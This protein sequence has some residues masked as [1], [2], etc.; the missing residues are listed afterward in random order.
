MRQLIAFVFLSVLSLQ[1]VAQSYHLSCTFTGVR[2]DDGSF[3]EGQT[4]SGSWTAAITQAEIDAGVAA[5][6]GADSV[7]SIPL[8]SFSLEPNPIP[9][10]AIAY[11]V[12][13]ANVEMSIRFCGVTICQIYVG[14]KVSSTDTARSFFGAEDLRVVYT[15]VGSAMPFDQSSWGSSS[16]FP[17]NYKWSGFQWNTVNSVL[18]FQIS[19]PPTSSRLACS[20]FEPP[21]RDTMSI[22]GQRVIPLKAML[23]DSSGNVVGSSGIG[24]APNVAVEF[25]PASSGTSSDLGDSVSG[26]GSARAGRQF[27]YADGKWRFNLSTRNFSNPGTYLVTMTSGDEAE[28]VIEPPCTVALEIR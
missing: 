24:S 13:T 20:G 3:F 7:Y 27:V 18:T 26:V 6:A 19:E 28:Y 11:A 10:G 14:G 5:A 17:I 1:G 16:P 25:F 21:V 23:Y 9:P 12:A 15:P 22:T 4:I 2:P 8:T